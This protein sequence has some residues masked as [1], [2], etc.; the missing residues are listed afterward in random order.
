VSTILKDPE[1]FY[2]KTSFSQPEIHRSIYTLSIDSFFNARHFVLTQGRPGQIH[3]H[4]FRVT[5]VVCQKVETSES[6]VFGFSEFRQIVQGEIDRFNGTL[7]NNIPP[8]SEQRE[9]TTE[10]LA[11]VIYQGITKRLPAL[12]KLES[13]TISESPTAHVTYREE[14]A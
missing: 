1:H 11:A 12:L 6:Y 3:T 9:P 2:E 5:V 7:L 10:N 4:T 8:F 13:V 14:V